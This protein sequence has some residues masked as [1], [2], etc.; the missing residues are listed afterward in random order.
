MESLF[1]QR[2]T[3][4]DL[5]A[6]KIRRQLTAQIERLDGSGDAELASL[7]RR[8]MAVALRSTEVPC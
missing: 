6:A 3:A 7:I 4:R 5:A 8:L 2:P 1:Y